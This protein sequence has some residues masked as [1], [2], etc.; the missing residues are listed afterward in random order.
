MNSAFGLFLCAKTVM[1]TGGKLR[2][3]LGYAFRGVNCEKSVEAA[4]IPTGGKE[5]PIISG[6]GT[7]GETPGER[8]PW[9]FLHSAL[10]FPCASQWVE[11]HCR[12]PQLRCSHSAT[13]D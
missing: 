5:I 1:P 12:L 7:P 8:Q 6:L 9:F 13:L 10:K 3:L 11:I 4:V 2:R